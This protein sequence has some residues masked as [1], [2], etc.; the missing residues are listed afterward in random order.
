M[1]K[2]KIYFDNCAYNR[3]FDEQT[4]IKIALE[5]EA[6]KHIQQLIVEK[7]TKQFISTLLKEP[8]DYTQWS[9]KHYEDVDLHEFNMRAVE[10]D[11]KN[12][13]R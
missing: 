6:K 1:E 11:R 13:V 12:P 3:P 8:F 2:I 9:R 5:T 10:F 7:N 4:Q